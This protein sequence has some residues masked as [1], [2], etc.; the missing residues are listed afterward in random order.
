MGCVRLVQVRLG[1]FICSGGNPESS[2]V[3]MEVNGGVVF[4][5]PERWISGNAGVQ[6]AP[7]EE[8]SM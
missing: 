6:D 8:N 3:A 5:A 1:C 4:G 7:L 2:Y